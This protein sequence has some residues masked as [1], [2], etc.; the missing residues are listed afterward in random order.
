MDKMDKAPNDQAWSAIVW[1]L[2]MATT[3]NLNYRAL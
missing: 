1:S 2:Y 3:K